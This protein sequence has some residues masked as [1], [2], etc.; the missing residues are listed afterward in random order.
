MAKRSPKKAPAIDAEEVVARRIVF[1]RRRQRLTL[2]QLSEIMTGNGY[3]V[4]AAMINKVETRPRDKESG[5]VGARRRIT[6]RELVAY[7]QALGLEPSDMLNPNVVMDDNPMHGQLQAV[8][9][10]FAP[11][12]RVAA[13]FVDYIRSVHELRAELPEPAFATLTRGRVETIRQDHD[14]LGLSAAEGQVAADALNRFHRLE[15]DK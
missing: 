1:E 2:Q 10:M 12:Y 8:D 11:L 5:E 3:P 13:A 6:V 9:R 4:S 15:A 7:C 14:S